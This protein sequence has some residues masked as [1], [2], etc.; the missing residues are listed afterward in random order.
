MLR[1]VIKLFAHRYNRS[2]WKYAGCRN[3]PTNEYNLMNLFA[4]LTKLNI[5]NKEYIYN[6]FSVRVFFHANINT[7]YGM[8]MEKFTHLVHQIRLRSGQSKRKRIIFHRSWKN[9]IMCSKLTFFFFFLT[10]DFKSKCSFSHSITISSTNN[11]NKQKTL[12]WTLFLFFLIKSFSV[13]LCCVE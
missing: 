1:Q 7:V 5:F 13:A 6:G 11:F 3:V 2:N 4:R 9:N 10:W 12:K 8:F